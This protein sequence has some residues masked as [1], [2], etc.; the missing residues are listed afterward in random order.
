MSV[1]KYD[2]SVTV[3][4]ACAKVTPL[5]ARSRAYSVANLS[6]CTA[7]KGLST[8]ASR[9]SMPSSIARPRTSIGSPR[10]VRSAMPRESTVAAARSTRSSLPSG[11]TMRRLS[12]RAR[13]TRPYSNT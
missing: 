5:C 12:L 11:S 8:S 2:T 1:P 7:S 10:I 3:S 13:S 6:T 9:M 4:A